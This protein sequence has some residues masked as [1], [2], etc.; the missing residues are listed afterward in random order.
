MKYRH[1]M[2]KLIVV[3]NVAMKKQ[4]NQQHV[5]CNFIFD[6]TAPRYQRKMDQALHKRNTIFLEY[7][8]T[9]QIVTLIFQS[10]FITDDLDNIGQGSQARTFLH[11]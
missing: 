7:K 10:A 5:F 11:R 6:I 8:L 4:R 1:Y 3:S 2:E 9:K